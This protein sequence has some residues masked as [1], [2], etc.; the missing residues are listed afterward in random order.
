MQT[1][2]Q[3]AVDAQAGTLTSRATGEVFQVGQ[4]STPSLGEL[5]ARAAQLAPAHAPLRLHHDTSSDIFLDHAL[6]G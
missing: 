4:F 3:F 2:Q 5:R 6:P 1:Q